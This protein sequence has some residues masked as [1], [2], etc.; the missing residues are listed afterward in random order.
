MKLTKFTPLLM[1]GLALTVAASG[2]KKKPTFLTP[3]ND[4]NKPKAYA[5]PT[6]PEYPG[7]PVN[8]FDPGQPTPMVNPTNFV[9]WPEDPSFFK[10]DTVLFAYDSSVIRASEKPKLAKIAD[11]LKANPTHALRVEGNCDERGTDQYNF[12]LGERRA[13]AAREE[14]I[15]LGADGSKILTMSYGRSRPADTGHSDAAHA[16]NRRDDFVLLT[17]P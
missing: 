2:C 3:L 8:P 1:I 4:P 11:H 17:P 13:L 6:E 12:T 7:L 5:G 9:G 16:R 14:L 10:E 15:S